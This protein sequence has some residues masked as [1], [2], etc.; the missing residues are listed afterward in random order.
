MTSTNPPSVESMTQQ[1]TE[2]SNTIDK[3]GAGIV[4]IAIL[5]VLL[6]AL[7]VFFLVFFKNLY[8]T[9]AK[10]TD[11]IIRWFETQMSKQ[12]DSDIVKTSVE[13]TNIIIDHL[14]YTCSM[15]KCD[16]TAVY[17]FH[18]GQFL[19][20]GCHIM[21]FSC[22]AEFAL[23][24]KHNHI[25]EQKDI[26]I[27]QIQNLCNKMLGH[28]SLVFQDMSSVP[29]S[30]M[31][32]WCLRFGMK[33]LVA[34]A[35]YNG[36]GHILGFATAEYYHQKIDHEDIGKAVSEVRRLADKVCITMDIGGNNA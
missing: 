4:A 13:S 27:S 28:E 25:S 32:E 24:S 31:E 1:V 36:D 6:M 19:L 11:Q 15:T 22:L 5:F 2:L 23:L 17:V 26:P 14:K 21:K 20:N 9:N 33:S 12:P 7:M 3:Y 35:V 18:N 30:P 8:D 10:R 34:Q 16:R 29:N